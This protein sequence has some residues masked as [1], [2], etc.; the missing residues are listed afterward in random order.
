MSPPE[1]ELALLWSDCW[2]W[3]SFMECYTS[4]RKPRDGPS[5]TETKAEKIGRAR[6]PRCV[7]RLPPLS[8]VCGRDGSAVGT[9]F[10]EELDRSGPRIAGS[11][12]AG[13]PGSSP[14]LAPGPASACR[15]S[16]APHERGGWTRA[17]DGRAEPSA[18]SW[19]GR[20][21]PDLAVVVTDAARSSC[22]PPRDGRRPAGAS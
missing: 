10:E 14:D 3:P 13:T 15:R 21:R 6:S 16:E 22:L 7:F 11:I 20:R 4:A 5:W 18:L 8:T 1:L 2:A 19:S 17:A 12:R 9:G